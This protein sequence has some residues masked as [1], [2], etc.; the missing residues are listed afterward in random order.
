MYVGFTGSVN[1]IF[2]QGIQM[3]ALPPISYNVHGISYG[4]VCMTHA[5]YMVRISEIAI[6]ISDCLNMFFISYFKCS[7]CLTYISQWAIQTFLLV[8][9]TAIVLL[10][11]SFVS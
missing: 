5:D 11:F 2:F 7:S 3:S 9:A 8:Y 4:P 6:I 10:C 1:V